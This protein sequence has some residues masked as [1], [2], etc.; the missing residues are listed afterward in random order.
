[1]KRL[2]ILYIVTLAVMVP[3]DFL[4]WGFWP[5]TSSNLKLAVLSES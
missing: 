2:V 4:F 3:L 5:G 1:M